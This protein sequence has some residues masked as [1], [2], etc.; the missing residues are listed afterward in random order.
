MSNQDDDRSGLFDYPI[1]KIIVG[2]I[3]LVSAYWLFR[4]FN[5]L[6]TGVRESFRI[7]WLVAFLYNSLG[8]TLTLVIL[9]IVGLAAILFGFLQYFREQDA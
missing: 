8:P 2:S 7:N 9:V 1:G 4:I 5:D 6:E 3:F